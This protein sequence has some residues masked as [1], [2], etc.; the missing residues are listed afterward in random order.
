MKNSLALLS[1]FALSTI[2]L[3][4]IWT[5]RPR[6][7]ATSVVTP[8]VPSNQKVRTEWIEDFDHKIF[9]FP[10]V[11][12]EPLDTTSLR[13][14]IRETALVRQKRVLEIGTG[15]GLISLCCAQAGASWIVSTDVNSNAVECARVNA[16]HLGFE[17]IMDVRLVDMANAKAFAVVGVEERFDVII[18]NPP[19]EEGEPKSIDQY[20]L[21][22]PNF[23]LMKSL[24]SNA[25]AYLMDDGQLYLAYG[26]KT[27]IQL[28]KNLAFELG[29]EVEVLDDRKLEDL[30]EVFLPGMLLKLTLS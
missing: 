30:E 21:Y 3:L 13:K 1:V 2:G 4:C 8:Q 15:S 14:L 5:V 24:L 12:W 27:A 16:Q 10:T 22:D 19:W 7:I 17:S 9:I 25:P 29:Y 18:S 26:C 6:S 28:L 23:E 20:A 11:F